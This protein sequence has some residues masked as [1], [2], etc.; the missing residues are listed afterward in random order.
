MYVGLS[1]V[2][3]QFAMPIHGEWNVR[4][5]IER[6]LLFGR[7]FVS[8]VFRD[9][10]VIRDGRKRHQSIRMEFVLPA[11]VDWPRFKA[12]LYYHLEKVKAYEM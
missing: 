11:R 12:N 2:Q 9:D 5:L 7:K 1:E 3:S 6:E 10:S 8:W 4:D